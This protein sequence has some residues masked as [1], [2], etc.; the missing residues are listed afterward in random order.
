MVEELKISSEL[1]YEYERIAKNMLAIV[2]GSRK[3]SD[4]NSTTHQYDWE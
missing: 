1:G 3:H 2:N 4:Y